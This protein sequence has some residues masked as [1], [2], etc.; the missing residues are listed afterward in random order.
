MPSP[1]AVNSLGASPHPVE[2]SE[3]RQSKES[4]GPE[5]VGNPPRGPRPESAQT[6][7]EKR[8]THS[9]LTLEIPYQMLYTFM[10]D[11]YVEHL[12]A[13]PRRVIRLLNSYR[14]HVKMLFQLCSNEA[15][16]PSCLD[17]RLIR[18]VMQWTILCELCPVRVAFLLHCAS[19]LRSLSEYCQNPDE[20]AITEFAEL[21]IF[22]LRRGTKGLSLH[23][24]VSRR[25]LP[26]LPIVSHNAQGPRPVGDT[27]DL[28]YELEHSTKTF[29]AILE[30]GDDARL[31]LKCLYNLTDG[32]GRNKINLSTVTTNLNPAAHALVESLLQHGKV[33]IEMHEARRTQVD[34]A[35]TDEV[36]TGSPTLDQTSYRR[37]T[38]VQT[39]STTP[40]VNNALEEE[41]ELLVHG[42]VE[43]VRDPATQ[44]GE[45][46]LDHRVSARRDREGWADS[47]GG[48]DKLD[49]D[50]SVRVLVDAIISADPPRRIGLYSPWGKGKSFVFNKIDCYL[51]ARSI[52]LNCIWNSQTSSFTTNQVIK[53]LLEDSSKM[54]YISIAKLHDQ[55]TKWCQGSSE[56]LT[57]KLEELRASNSN[58][59]TR[60]RVVTR[61]QYRCTMNCGFYIFELYLLL[62]ELVLLFFVLPARTFLGC[63]SS[64]LIPRGV[65][66][67]SKVK[68]A[69]SRNSSFYPEE[70]DFWCVSF[71]AWEHENARSIDAALVATIAKAV[72]NRYGSI[73]SDAYLRAELWM[74]SLLL[75]L[76][77]G[78][79]SGVI[80][81]LVSHIPE[82]TD[83]RTVSVVVA[84]IITLGGVLATLWRLCSPIAPVS[85]EIRRQHDRGG[86]VEAQLGFSNEVLGKLQELDDILDK[87]E[88]M[89]TA[90]DLVLPSFLKDKLNLLYYMKIPRI[91]HFRQSRVVILVDDLDRCNKSVALNIFR[92]CNALITEKLNSFIICFAMDPSLIAESIAADES[93][94]FSQNGKN[95]KC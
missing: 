67:E 89:K 30:N 45:D 42:T 58:L 31:Y 29:N 20:V 60:K 93:H 36:V 23:E 59:W 72:E 16:S 52:K 73:Y 85:E 40:D 77:C 12:D 43:D 5:D 54:E 79:A 10:F 75:V 26:R 32:P 55:T 62:G 4:K 66:E 63:V 88:N 71:N 70:C 39:H 8:L 46:R 15:I 35:A 18:R 27:S 81:A 6:D 49:Y 37:R 2:L 44:I 80:F 61:G 57:Q 33:G 9:D 84:A 95:K 19:S 82:T 94:S 76:L 69:E 11:D 65:P 74:Y 38:L 41:R 7:E 22:R 25:P 34:V 47:T 91:E 92:T 64:K 3:S 50:V 13:N 86:D 68:A 21:T 56:Q 1:E 53:K 17:R 87:P 48:P 78:V 28:V 90:W 83:A 14:V 51:K 24:L